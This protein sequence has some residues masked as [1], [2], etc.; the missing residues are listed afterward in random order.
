MAESFTDT[1]L[2]TGR[3]DAALHYATE[4]HRRQLRKGTPVPYAAHLLAVASLVLEMHGDEDEAIGALLHD[5]VEDGGGTPA[6]EHIARE[7]GDAVAAIVL[8][9][10]DAIDDGQRPAGDDRTDWFERKQA[11]LDAFPA[12]SPAALRVSLAD[13]LHNARSILIDYR[14]HGD[15]VWARFKQG[16]GLAT[17]VYYRE[18][19]AAFEREQH[20]M[21]E[22]AAPAVAELRRTVDAITALAVKH[23]GPDTRTLFAD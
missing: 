5:V 23:Q 6:L 13:K 17:R 8:A 21:G 2:L 20:R 16:Q 11:Y 14:T 19:A 12:K 3:F 7:Y 10:S 9:N 4:H 18:L 22:F 15:A 1:P